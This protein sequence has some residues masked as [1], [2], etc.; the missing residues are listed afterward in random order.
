MVSVDKIK[1]R[2]GWPGTIVTIRGTGFSPNRDENLVSFG[3]EPALVIAAEPETLVVLVNENAKGGKTAV[4]VGGISSATGGDFKVLPYPAPDDHLKAGPPRFFHGPQSGTPKTNVQDQGVL[5]LFCASPAPAAPPTEARRTNEIAVIERALLYWRESSYGSTTW[6][7]E[8]SDWLTLPHDHSFYY[9]T[10]ADIDRTRQSLLFVSARAMTFDGT[11]ITNGAG[12]GWIRIGHPTPLSWEYNPGYAG[13]GSKTLCL[14]RS[15]NLL[16][17][18]TMNGTLIAY[19]VT[20]PLAAV[21]L[22]RLNTGT[23]PIWDIDI[24]PARSRA[25][26]AA[27]QAGTNLVDITN[28]AAMTLIGGPLSATSGSFRTRLAVNGSDFFSNAGAVLRMDRLDAAGALTRILETGLAGW[29][30]DLEIAGNLLLVSTYGAGLQI[31]QITAAGAVLLSSWGPGRRIAAVK[32]AG[33]RAYMAAYGDGIIVVDCSNPAAPALLGEHKLKLPAYDLE[34]RGFEVIVAA[35]SS[36]VWSVDAGNLA[37]MKN[38]GDHLSS[39][40][41]FGIKDYQ[42]A[43]DLALNSNGQ[44]KNRNR[45]AIDALNAYMAKTGTPLSVLEAAFEG[46]VTVHDGQVRG[47][48]TLSPDPAFRDGGDVIAFAASKGLI[49][50]PAGSLWTTYAHEM[51][52]WLGMG[53]IYREELAD[54]SVIQGTAQNWC[55]SG[56]DSR[57][58][59]LCGHWISDTMKWYRSDATADSNVLNLTWSVTGQ[60]DDIHEIAAA[61]H[62][63]GRCAEPL[64]SDPAHRILGAQLFC[65]SAPADAAGPHL[66]SEPPS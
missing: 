63:P 61:W 52:H 65:R 7:P 51:A 50:L 37:A 21:E 43:L 22:G 45:V 29:I 40:V 34:I 13:D 10:N 23:F 54:G 36:V 47:W 16:L 41:E 18:G 53:D 14:R 44:A 27:G 5:F 38:L 33:G 57:G 35:G 42:D 66:R 39:T 17:A 32:F 64:S 1:P 2:R 4:E 30:T 24:M 62:E 28:L 9:W 8:Y 48:S 59:L 12:N 19:D 3:D 49:T 58:A 46:F 15:G 56:D 31:F 55:L 26:I 6:R 11:T 20:N 60:H 25:V